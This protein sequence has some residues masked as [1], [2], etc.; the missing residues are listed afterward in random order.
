MCST[1][2]NISGMLNVKDNND[3]EQIAQSSRRLVDLTQ[4]VTRVEKHEQACSEAAP[5]PGDWTG[6]Y[7][8]WSGWEDVEELQ[9]EVSCEEGRLEALLDKNTNPMGHCHSHTKVH[10]SRS[11]WTHSL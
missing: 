3:E 4:A 1:A 10:R 7:K 11:D 8:Y 6:S 2:A 9:A 5:V